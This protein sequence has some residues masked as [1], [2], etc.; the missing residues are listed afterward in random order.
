MKSRLGSHIIVILLGW[1]AWAKPAFSRVSEPSRFRQAFL[2]SRSESLTYEYLLKLRYSDGHCQI[3]LRWL[4]KQ[5]KSLFGGSSIGSIRLYSGDDGESHIEEIDP[6]S[7]PDWMALH[8]VTGI[9]FRSLEPGFFCDWH[10]AP[11]PK[12]R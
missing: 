7:H 10:V 2:A 8:G 11:K 3:I 1:A 6:A 9:V 4:C 5:D 12:I